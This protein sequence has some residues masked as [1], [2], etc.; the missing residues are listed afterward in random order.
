[1]NFLRESIRIQLI[2][3]FAVCLLASMLI[4]F[5]SSHLFVTHDKRRD[6]TEGQVTIDENARELV[7]QV[8]QM[9]QNVAGL[10]KE[11][12]IEDPSFQ[13]QFLNR[14]LP[15]SKGN[16]QWLS[17]NADPRSVYHLTEN[18]LIQ[19]L[20]NVLKQQSNLK[21]LVTDLDGKVLYKS[22]G[23]KDTQVDIRH[24]IEA[25]T[26]TRIGKHQEENPTFTSFYP[27]TLKGT[28]AFLLVSGSPKPT[29]ITV[30]EPGI[31]P[32]LL[33]FATFILC[34]Y[35]LTKRKMQEIESISS[36]LREIAKGNLTF[37]IKEKSKDEV[38][39]LATNINYMAEEL[40][41]MIEKQRQIEKMKDELITNVSH[42]LRTPLTSIMGYMRLVK[43]H[44]YQDQAQLNE[45][46]DIAYGKSEQL[47]KLIED[48]FDFTRLNQE[49]IQLKKEQVSLGQMLEQLVEELVPIA[50]ENQVV[51]H[52]E[53]PRERM[54]LEID[55]DLMVRALENIVMNA[56]KHSVHPGTIQVKM[57][58]NGQV[59][60]IIVS[61]PCEP[62][63]EEEVNRLFERF[64]RV[65]YSRSSGKGGAGLGLAITKNIIELHHGTID[66][67]YQEPNISLKIT[68][69]FSSHAARK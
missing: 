66:V 43:D 50:H 41:Q 13:H 35:F 59:I 42:D 31:T 68:L 16:D 55:P 12:G 52:K 24:V 26:A 48:L 44:N 14:P 63:S 23:A 58:K 33:A 15:S 22:A 1:V 49:G 53:I 46:V 39:S 47:K 25:A 11:L 45:Y 20:I 9:N 61:N 37:R 5:A 28:K 65:D 6:Y 36:G 57:Q 54:L 60:Q 67:D 27:I 10:V 21:T 7:K 64:Y 38:G 2:L 30:S 18:E 19:Y 40:H 69:P 51:F 62:L 32:Y 56:I 29:I 3:S 17:I 8:N 4:G 34:F